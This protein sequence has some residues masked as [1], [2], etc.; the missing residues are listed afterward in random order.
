MH[1]PQ[2]HGGEPPKRRLVECLGMVE[3]VHRDFYVAIISLLSR[4]ISSPAAAVHPNAQSPCGSYI[5]NPCETTRE[6]RVA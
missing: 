3:I 4:S 2:D 5:L 1:E 6:G